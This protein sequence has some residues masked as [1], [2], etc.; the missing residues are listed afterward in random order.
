LKSVQGRP[1]RAGIDK[2]SAEHRAYARTPAR[3]KG[4]T[5]NERT[6][7]TGRLTAKVN[8]FF[9]HEEIEFQKTRDKET[10][11]DDDYPADYSY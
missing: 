7:I 9:R 11:D 5:D 3:G 10:E 6:Y 1:F 4:H 2:D 8:L